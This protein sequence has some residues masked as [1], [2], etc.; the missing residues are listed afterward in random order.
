[1]EAQVLQQN[2]LSILCLVDRLLHLLANAV[3]CENHA[4]AKQFLE[5]GN[6][7]LETVLRVC[8]SVGPAEVRHEDDGFG[9]ILDGILDRG[10]GSDD[11][12]V[13]CDFVAV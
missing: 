10:E 9:A 12:L 6:Y 7:R 8:L 4:F 5:L 11:T 1:V 13:V 2:D 3:V